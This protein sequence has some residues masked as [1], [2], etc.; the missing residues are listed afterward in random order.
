MATLP[1]HQ[2]K[3]LGDVVL[4]KLLATIEARAA[5][6]TAYV[7]LVADPPGR[8]LYAKNGFEECMPAGLGMGQLIKVPRREG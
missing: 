8:R 1:E 6:G 7:N 3:G 5:V 2:R 4:K